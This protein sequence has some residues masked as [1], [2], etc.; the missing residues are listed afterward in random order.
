MAQTFNVGSR[1]LFVTLTAWLFFALGAMASVSALL[2]NATLA[3]W[4]PGL[5]GL[6]AAQ[7]LPLLTGLLIGYLPWVVGT[8]LVMSL[9]TMVSAVG[10]HLRLEW[11][12]RCFIALLGLAIAANLLGLWL[13][14]E[15]VQS[16]VE[17]T[18]SRSPLPPAA[19]YV[20]GSFVTASQM[21]AVVVTLA[22]CVVLGWI[23]RRLMSPAVRQEF[24]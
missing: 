18:L 23:M 14:H 13:Q 1:S 16:V 4:L 10:L 7:P 2:Q 15:V 8:G 3:S 12:R 21:M 22:G 6:G 17:A 20:F 24:A 19:A 11:A 5:R 9:A